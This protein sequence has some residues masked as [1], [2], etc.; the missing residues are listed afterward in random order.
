MRSQ[1]KL[2]L[3]HKP[4]D[5]DKLGKETI[6]GDLSGTLYYDA[7]SSGLGAEIVMKY[8]DYSDYYINNDPSLGVYFNITGNTDTSSNMSANGNMHGTVT[9]KGMYPG[10]VV[11]DQVEIKS[12]AAGGGS[13][14]ITPSGFSAVAVDYK[15][16]NEGL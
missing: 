1:K 7:Q 11:Y 5:T 3:M 15:V 8:T 14:V 16:R 2:T 10:T 6:N 12:G 13:Y 4:S 9:C